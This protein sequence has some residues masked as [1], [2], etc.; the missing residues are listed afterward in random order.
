MSRIACHKDFITHDAVFLSSLMDTTFLY[1]RRSW[2]YIYIYTILRSRNVLVPGKKALVLVNS[3]IV[4]NLIDVVKAHGI[5]VTILSV[6]KT[7][8]VSVIDQYKSSTFD[9]IWSANGLIHH[10]LQETNSFLFELMTCLDITNGIAVYTLNYLFSSSSKEDIVYALYNENDIKLLIDAFNNDE[11]LMAPFNFETNKTI[12]DNIISYPPYGMETNPIHLKA[13]IPSNDVELIVTSFGTYVAHKPFQTTVLPSGDNSFSLTGS[14]QDQHVFYA[15]KNYGIYE[16]HIVNLLEKYISPGDTVLQAGSHFGI[17]V[18]HMAR[19]V[20]NTGKV[21]AYEMHH[22]T[23]KYLVN[24]VKVNNLFDRVSCYNRCIT[25]NINEPIFY[26]TYGE[27]EKINACPS[28]TGGM[29]V[30]NQFY[31]RTTKAMRL[32]DLDIDKL[33]LIVID[34]EGAEKKVLDGARNLLMKHKPIILIEL[35]G[36]QTYE[37]GTDAVRKEIDDN[38]LTIKNMGYD[39]RRIQGHDYIGIPL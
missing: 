34:C 38:I 11:C 19:L 21:Y 20:G 39:V 35:C 28:G 29:A 33:K 14:F 31:S 8:N 36:G 10:T 24:N 7:D 5:D 22:T 12:Y 18:L 13:S 15:V 26:P 23:F 17:H 9:F 1:H 30:H 27:L 32:D 3:D 2:E 6:N 16:T 4:D 37:D 25:D